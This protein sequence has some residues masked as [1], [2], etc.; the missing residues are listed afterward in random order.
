MQSVSHASY[1]KIGRVVH[2]NF[3]VYAPTSSSSSGF[4]INNLPFTVAGSSHYA[5]GSCYT[6]NTSTNYVF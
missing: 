3:Y 1:T 4:V 2:I 5:I 6:Q